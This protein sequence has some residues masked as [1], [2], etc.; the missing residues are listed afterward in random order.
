MVSLEKGE[1]NANKCRMWMWQKN[2]EGSQ[3][4][5]EG[6]LILIKFRFF[7]FVLFFDMNQR[8]IVQEENSWCGLSG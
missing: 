6:G 5:T 8:N 1:R 3:G 7:C 4:M 2:L